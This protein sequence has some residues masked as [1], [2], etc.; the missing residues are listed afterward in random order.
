MTPPFFLD[1]NDLDLDAFAR[2]ILCELRELT[3]HPPSEA[4][5]GNFVFVDTNLCVFFFRSQSVIADLL[6]SR[7]FACPPLYEGKSALEMTQDGTTSAELTAL[8]KG[9]SLL[10]GEAGHDSQSP[11]ELRR[12]QSL[13]EAAARRQSKAVY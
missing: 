5:P 12:V 1:D 7:P 3:A 4:D 13:A 2:T 10:T 9:Q 6:R 8:L 11:V